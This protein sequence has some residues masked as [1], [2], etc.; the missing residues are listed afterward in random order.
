VS[1]YGGVIAEHAKNP[2]R[3]GALQEPDRSHEG[4]NP[5][6]GDRVRI[7]VHLRDGRIAE[8]GFEA[9]ACMVSIAAASIL[10]DLIAG[11]PIEEAR[12]LDDARLLAALQTDLRPAR[13]GCALLPLQV[14]REAL[15]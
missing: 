4:T 12:A 5:L 3:R 10:G 1:L 9:D 2:R 15:R 14:L 7:D 11:A 8:M 13:L 6:C